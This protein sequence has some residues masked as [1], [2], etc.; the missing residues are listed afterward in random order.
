[1][2]GIPCSNE[3]T[4]NHC[5][6]ACSFTSLSLLLF[7]KKKKNP[8]KTFPAPIC[9]RFSQ[10]VS[11]G[12]KKNHSCRLKKA[13]RKCWIPRWVIFSK[14]CAKRFLLVGMQTRSFAKT[15]IKIAPCHLIC[16]SWCHTA[17]PFGATKS[18]N[19]PKL[20]EWIPSDTAALA[21]PSALSQREIRR[22]RTVFYF[23][24]VQSSCCIIEKTREVR[25]CTRWAE[26]HWAN[27]AETTAGD[28]KTKKDDKYLPRFSLLC[29]P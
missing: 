21:L 28:V 11:T 18:S 5:F 25:E 3:P 24:H 10:M 22:P 2:K 27:G 7:C 12:Q 8:L 29:Q 19:G 13:S 20:K 6:L 15:S 14:S 1:M 9:K 23:H 26:T 16:T 17:F 4:E